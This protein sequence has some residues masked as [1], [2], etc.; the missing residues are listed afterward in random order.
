LTVNQSHNTASTTLPVAR[1]GPNGV[2]APMT[3]PIAAAGNTAATYTLPARRC[4]R[5]HL[6]RTPGQICTNAITMTTVASAT[7]A[8]NNG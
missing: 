6:A 8:I 4:T 3:M 2:A 5:G 1:M 7:W